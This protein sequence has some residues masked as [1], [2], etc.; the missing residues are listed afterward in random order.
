LERGEKAAGGRRCGY[1]EG[2]G[3]V[4]EGSAVPEHFDE[5]VCEIGVGIDEP[6]GPGGKVAEVDAKAIVGRGDG[7]IRKTILVERQVG[8]RVGQFGEKEEAARGVG[9]EA[10]VDGARMEE[11]EQE[12]FQV[13]DGN[14]GKREVRGVQVDPVGKDGS[15]GLHQT[16]QIVGEA[17]L[18]FRIGFPTL[19]KDQCGG[20][21][22]AAACGKLRAGDAGGRRG[23]GF[24]VAEDDGEV[25][26]GLVDKAAMEALDELVA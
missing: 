6:E 15:P 25:I 11:A 21:G 10:Q 26:V 12:E 23:G 4:E 8:W 20:Q 19:K 3:K 1:V 13:G 17:G 2:R 14:W 5:K 18:G 16:V 22:G 7:G 24:Q 9:V